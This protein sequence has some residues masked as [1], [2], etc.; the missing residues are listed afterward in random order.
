TNGPMLRAPSA[1]NPPLFSFGRNGAANEVGDSTASYDFLPSVSFDDLQSSLETA[2]N[3]FKLTQFPSSSTGQG[4]ILSANNIAD[5]MAAASNVAQNGSSARGGIPPPVTR[6]GRSGSI[7][8][9]PSTSTRQSSISSIAPGPSSVVDAST[10]PSAARPRRQSHYPPVSNT[11]IAKPPRKSIGPGVIETDFGGH[12]AQRRRP[13]VSSHTGVST[14]LSRASIDAGAGVGFETPRNLA[15]SRAAKSKSMH[16]ALPRSNTANLS[17]PDHGR[18]STISPRSPRGGSKVNNGGGGGS[19]QARR[20]SGL[21]GVPHASHASGLGARTISPTDTRRMKRMSMHQ[22]PGQNEAVTAP[23]PPLERREN[24]RSPSMIPRKASGTPS[25]SRTTPDINRK[26]Y[27]SG[28]S[29]TSTNSFN[30]VRTS[31][32]SIQPRAAATGAASRLPAPKS[33]TP[34][35]HNSHSADDDE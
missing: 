12:T 22:V 26:S 33:L 27:S 9:R 13:S 11:H 32:G 30:T 3:N 4:S 5:K 21:P 2:S 10:G 24:S 1:N 28:L 35:N 18:L 34:H 7:L 8:R 14:D 16:Q 29:I 25:S 20:Q 15:S 23:P 31:T 6:T 19:A 17:T